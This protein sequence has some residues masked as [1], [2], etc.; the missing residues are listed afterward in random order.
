MLAS[1]G[2]EP[3][4][5]LNQ[6]FDPLWWNIVRKRTTYAFIGQWGLAEWL[7]LMHTTVLAFWVARDQPK[8]LRL[9][10]R[11]SLGVGYLGIVVSAVGGD[12]LRN[13]MILDAQLWRGIWLSSVLVHLAVVG[14]FIRVWREPG[15][16]RHARYWWLATLFMS[17]VAGWHGGFFFLATPLALMAFLVEWWEE[18]ERQTP[19]WWVT[20]IEMVVLVL[21]LVLLA[22]FVVIL[23]HNDAMV[24]SL[25]WSFLPQMALVTGILA[26]TLMSRTMHGPAS[27]WVAGVVVLMV[28]VAHQWDQRKDWVRYRDESPVP[29][30]DL[31]RLL[32]GGKSIYWEGDPTVPWILLHRASYFSC[33]QGTGSLFSRDTALHYQQLYERFRVLNAVEFLQGISYCEPVPDQSGGFPGRAGVMAVCRASPGLG[34]LVLLHPVAGMGQTVWRAPVTFHYDRLL[35]AQRQSYSTR[36]FY[37][38]SCPVQK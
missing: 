4:V 7:P 23:L 2:I 10:T 22:K 30:A 31:V 19:S 14:R 20:G 28:A 38:V 29:P 18:D 1:A 12:W 34:A 25:E 11:V 3:F 33:S 21:M 9:F 17:W 24:L 15:D 13:V 6:R 27:G 36:V 8:R 16:R 5:R 37:V 32:P 26:W 35:G